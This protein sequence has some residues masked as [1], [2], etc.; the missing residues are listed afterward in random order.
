MREYA[1]RFRGEHGTGRI[2]AITS[3]DTVGN[4]PYGA[5]KGALDRITQAAA[6]ELAGLGVTSNAVNPGPTDTGWITDGLRADIVSSTPLGRVGTPQ[7]CANLVTFL[8]SP[9]GGWVNG[10]L[11]HSN[12]GI[13]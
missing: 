6:K 4:L 10:Q 8:C 7:D 13:A 5:S 1:Q 12:G 3:D 9:E 11:L 2:V